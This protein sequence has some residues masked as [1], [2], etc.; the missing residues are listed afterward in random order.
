ML[1]TYGAVL[2]LVL[3]L[4]AATGY[5]AMHGALLQ[6]V[7]AAEGGRGG[8]GRGGGGG[9][10]GRGGGGGGRSQRRGERGCVS[11]RNHLTCI[12]TGKVSS[13]VKVRTHRI[14]I[15]ATQHIG[16]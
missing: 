13:L 7:T 8:G 16:F 1:P 3:T 2:V 15:R 6:A 5:V 9:E 12:A 14:G 11:R 10:R 4:C